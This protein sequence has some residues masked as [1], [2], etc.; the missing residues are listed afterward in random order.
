[1]KRPV[2][3]LCT[4]LPWAG[5]V[6]GQNLPE[7]KKLVDLR[8]KISTTVITN[9]TSDTLKFQTAAY[10]YTPYYETKVSLTIPPGQT[11]SL[12]L[13][14][15]YPDFIW[16]LNYGLKLY[17]APGRR[18]HAHIN[19]MKTGAA[20]V[21]FTGDLVGENDYYMAYQ[22]NFKGY[23]QE[24]RRYYVEAS[25]LKD[26]NTFPA[27][28][29]SINNQVLDF[30]KKYTGPLPSYFKSFEES[31]LV[32]NAAYRKYNVLL[33]RQSKT[34]NKNLVN[35]SYFDFE[36]SVSLNPDNFVLNSS[37]IDYAGFS[38]FFRSGQSPS[39][40]TLIALADSLVKPSELSDAL[41]MNMLAR[42]FKDSKPQFNTI[43]P[44]LAFYD[45]KNKSAVASIITL[46][47]SLPLVGMP[48]PRIKLANTKG[49]SISLGDFKGKPVILNFW[50]SW[51]APCLAAL[52]YENS[53]YDKHS[54]KGLAI[55]NICVETDREQ[56][57]SLSRKKGLRMTNL[58]A[59]PDEYRRLKRLYNV[60]GLPRSL[61]I[62]K[63][64]T[65]MNNYY[66]AAMEIKDEEVEG[67]L[68]R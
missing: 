18:I 8:G 67:L 61:L 45:L 20:Q 34:G 41:K 57:E 60:E 24:N 28:A 14:L 29:D 12:K 11:D 9:R 27:V 42:L 66:K 62:A 68:L 31:R 23:E 46:K 21:K 64:G 10:Y 54:A 49:D 2:L 47:N 43:F 58:Y 1:M 5:F 35:A 53:L 25:R 19:S 59:T 63:D 13:P 50:A 30:L 48:S 38:M 16:L 51:C 39:M 33:D 4:L 6:Y 7:D 32:Y 17:N 65:V 37:Y 22:N 52:P 36:K 56:W 15:A 3:L 44:K 26:L 55:V 40:S